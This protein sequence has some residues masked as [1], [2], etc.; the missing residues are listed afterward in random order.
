MRSI[1]N[2]ARNIW[3]A[4]SQNIISK[5]LV[6]APKW[7]CYWSPVLQSRVVVLILVFQEAV[8]LVLFEFTT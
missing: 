3:L 6:L 5:M 7:Y 1:F 2:E 4:Y 8:E